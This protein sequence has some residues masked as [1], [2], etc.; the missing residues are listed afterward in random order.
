MTRKKSTLRIFFEHTS[1]GE[2]YECSTS[3]MMR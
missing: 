3:K 1:L 2:S